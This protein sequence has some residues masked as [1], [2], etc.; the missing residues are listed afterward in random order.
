M[1][2][3]ASP[4]LKKIKLHAHGGGVGRKA[5]NHHFWLWIAFFYRFFR[6][7]KKIHA[8]GHAHM[9]N[10]RTGNHCA[11]PILRR[12]GVETTVRPSLAFYNTHDE[13]ERFIAALGK[14]RKL[15]A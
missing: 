15:L 13:I 7:N 12:M 11:Q 8:F 9:L 4:P 2:R 10:L 1:P 6:L 5:Q 3:C 14:V